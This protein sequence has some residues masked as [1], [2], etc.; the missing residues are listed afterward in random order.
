MPT[1]RTDRS[2]E[3]S[4]IYEEIGELARFTPRRGGQTLTF[5]IVGPSI[6]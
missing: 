1:H 5:R 3:K 4:Q 2:K 6:G